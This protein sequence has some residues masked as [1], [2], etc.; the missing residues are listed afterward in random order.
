MRTKLLPVVALGLWLAGVRA[1]DR[2]GPRVPPGEPFFGEQPPV[3]V[4]FLTAADVRLGDDGQTALATYEDLERYL[5]R[6]RDQ[7]RSVSP[8]HPQVHIRASAGSSKKAFMRTW[9]QCRLI[10]GLQTWVTKEL[11][12]PIRE[13]L[14]RSR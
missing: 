5:L 6:R 4:L 8:L 3:I 11:E 10:L 2:A 7:L 12:P 13:P 1:D 9:E 14:R